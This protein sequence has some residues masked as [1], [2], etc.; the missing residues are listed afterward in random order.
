MSLNESETFG[1]KTSSAQELAGAALAAVTTAEPTIG[2]SPTDFFAH[3]SD[4]PEVAARKESRIKSEYDTASHRLPSLLKYVDHTLLQNLALHNH[5]PE[6]IQTC[7]ICEL[8]WDKASIPSTFLPLSPCNHWIHYRCLIWLATRE[9]FHKDKCYT[10]HIQLY[11][12][13]GIS[14]LTIATRTSLSMGNSHT[15]V[16]MPGTHNLVT[17]SVDSY[18]QDCQ[19]IDNTITHYFLSQ[20]EKPPGFSDNSPDLVQCF[21]DIIEDLRRNSRPQSEWLKWST[22]TGS[23]LFGMLVA[24]KMRRFLV[25]HH[26][27]IMHTEAWVAWEDGCRTLQNR[28]LDTIHSE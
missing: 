5:P 9:S 21:N 26:D 22:H 19:V 7:I 11:E 25:E 4:S 8:Q 10:C 18:E 17:S 24:I 23:F 6:Q 16:L 12:W 13:D 20:L 3:H 15:P 2:P 14:A 28:I 27:G 1:A